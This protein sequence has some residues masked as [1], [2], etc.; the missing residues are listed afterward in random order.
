MD[1]DI[2]SFKKAITIAASI[3]VM[4]IIINGVGSIL[5]DMPK[6]D[7]AAPEDSNNMSGESSGG[8]DDENDSIIVKL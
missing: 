3:A 4:V 1:I 6:G 7:A 2:E 8:Y 5:T